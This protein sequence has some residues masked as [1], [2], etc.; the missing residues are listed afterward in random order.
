MKTAPDQTEIL[1]LDL[2]RRV[3][4]QQENSEALETKLKIM[5]MQESR[6]HFPNDLVARIARTLA[7]CLRS[8]GDWEQAAQYAKMAAN[9]ERREGEAG[10][11]AGGSP[12]RLAE[13]EAD[14]DSSVSRER[15][16]GA[17]SWPETSGQPPRRHLP[18]VSSWSAWMSFNRRALKRL[19]R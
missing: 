15:A 4:L 14:A 13:S 5:L 16:E 11:P 10:Q 18:F 19:G 2:A 3:D 1:L 17:G 7:S 9:L 8:R 6:G 12:V